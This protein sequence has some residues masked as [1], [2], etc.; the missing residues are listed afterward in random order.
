MPKSSEHTTSD[1]C[2]TTLSDILPWYQRLQHLHQRLAPHFARREPFQRT[3]RFLQAI[4][5]SV[6]RKNGWQV[7]EQAR[8]ANPYGMQR[9][10]SQASWD[11]DGVRDEIRSLALQTL[12]TE[13]LIAA[14]DETSFLKRGKHSAGV[15]KQHHGLTDDVRNCQVGVFLSLIT[16][17]G[18]T[19]VDRELYL[20]RE[21]TDDPARCRQAGIPETVTF[22]TKPHLAQTLL[23][24]LMHAHVELDWVV[25]D[26]VYGSNP[27]L[28]TFLESR[29]QPYVMA[30]TSQEAV[31]VDLSALGVRRL[32]VSD[33]PLLFSAFPW[34]P[35]ALSEGTKGPRTFEW[36][37]LPL[38][39]QGRDDGW[40]RLLIRRTPDTDP[41]YAFFLVF[42]PPTASL[43]EVVQALGARWRIEEDFANAKDLGLDHYEVRS[44]VGWYRHITLVLLAL[45]FLTSLLK[46]ARASPTD[47][48]STPGCCPLSVPEARHLLARLFF[49][50]PS[51]TSL[52]LRW[53]TWRRRHQHRAS[54]F[55]IRRRLRTG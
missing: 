7:A 39:H 40:H 11:A 54:V 47:P 28:R 53:S 51:S 35:L 36:A 33:L 34:Q 5:S 15:G 12:G 22:A 46:A 55:H 50:P 30:V 37:C 38:W 32:V 42:A 29:Q 23:E 18:H 31:V 45:A 17:T 49:V 21:W 52:L 16:P 27:S 6:E 43:P 44:F 20:P 3:L 14:I 1:P 10:L 26:S 8:E 4:L 13:K 25:A 48:V 41:A 24:R 9:L 19:L 2:M